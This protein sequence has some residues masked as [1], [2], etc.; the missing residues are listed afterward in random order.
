MQD[1]TAMK[2]TMLWEG[3]IHLS[4][5]SLINTTFLLTFLYKSKE[6]YNYYC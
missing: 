6:N 1:T 5:L 3:S 4:F 2:E